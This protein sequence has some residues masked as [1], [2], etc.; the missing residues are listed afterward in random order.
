MRKEWELALKLGEDGVKLVEDVKVKKDSL[1]RGFVFLNTISAILWEGVAMFLFVLSLYLNVFGDVIA[2]SYIYSVEI[3]FVLLSI[4]FLIPVLVILPYFLRATWLFIKHGPIRSSMNQISVALLKTLI[5]MGAINTEYQKLR[6]ITKHDE[7]G[8]VF[9][10]LEGGTNREKSI[11]LDTLQEIL[12][13]VENPRYILIRKSY[14]LKRLGR[15]DYHAVPSIIGV[16]K[17]YAQYFAKMWKKH[18]GTMELVYT[19]NMDGRMKLLQA[20][21]HSLSSHFVSRSERISRWC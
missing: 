19:R 11:F 10:H 12:S 17:T 7:G 16:R 8:A 18:V 6:I 2:Q 15:L 1:P 4:G 14:L 9:C 20:R 5:F 3:F 21:N 13:P